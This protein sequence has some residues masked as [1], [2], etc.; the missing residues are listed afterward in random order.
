MIDSNI[1]LIK[2]K[3]QGYNSPDYIHNEISKKYN[4]IDSDTFKKKLADIDKKLQNNNIE[5]ALLYCFD[6]KWYLHKWFP[7][8]FPKSIIPGM[9]LD[10][11]LDLDTIKKKLKI[12]KEHGFY[13]LKLLPYEQKIFRNKYAKIIEIAKIVEK[14]GMIL[15]I[16]AAYG[17]RYVYKTNGVEIAAEVLNHGI[18]SPIIISH[19]GMPKVFDVMSLMLEYENLHMDISFTLPY[20]QGSRIIDD[21]AFTLKKMD[22]KRV[23]YG[24]DYPYVDFKESYKVFLEFVNNYLISEDKK[25]DILKNNFNKLLRQIDY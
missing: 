9:L 1:H 13:F 24:S 3:D 23:L 7:V 18:K 14:E 2:V 21:Y 4:E 10:V 16:C 8:T 15:T 5:K 25:N 17:S 6:D 19:G 22:Y 12:L 11:D 20:W